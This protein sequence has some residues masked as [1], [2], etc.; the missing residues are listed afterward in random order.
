MSAMKKI[1]AWIYDPAK[2]LVGDKR[3]KAILHEVFCSAPERCDVYTKCGSCLF[4]SGLRHC[5]YGKKNSQSGY[6]RRAMRH[7]EWM[8][9]ARAKVDE[10]DPN[11]KPLTAWKRIFKIGDHYYLP[12]SHISKGGLGDNQPLESEWVEAGEINADLLDRVCTAQ[13]TSLMGGIMPSYQE[14]EVPK[15]IAD[16]K[17]NYPDL[18]DLLS[19]KQ[20]A[21]FDSVDYRGRY[22][23]ITTCPPGK[24]IF[25]TTQWDWDGELLHGRSM[26]FQPCKGKLTITVKPEPGEKVQITDNAQVGPS[27]VFID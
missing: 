23:D 26:L 15:L 20:K 2:S 10:C 13:P 3:D 4:A 25:Y 27:T 8:K 5:R 7:H 14:K 11:I 21:R 1:G 6:T 9:D 16:L 17:Q 22:A 12:Y 18:F 24:Y 19:D